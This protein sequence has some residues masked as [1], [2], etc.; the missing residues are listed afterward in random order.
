M[1]TAGEVLPMEVSMWEVDIVVVEFGWLKS[2]I[3]DEEGVRIVK[4][5][6]L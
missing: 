4:K 5:D 1:T 3:E 2:G 6:G